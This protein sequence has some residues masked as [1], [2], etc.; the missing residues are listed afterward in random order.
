MKN[1]RVQIRAYGY[2]ADF[3]VESEDNSKAFEDALV[4]KLGKNDIKWEKDGFNDPF[5]TWIT[6][7]EVIDANAHQRS[8]QSEEGSR[9][10]VG[11][12]AT[13]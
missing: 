3:N 1:F 6:Y 7:E 12:T 2:Y 11:G 8:L 10:R 4:D 13:G 9:N 5:K